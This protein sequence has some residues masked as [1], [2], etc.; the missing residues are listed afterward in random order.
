MIIMDT[1]IVEQLHAI[2]KP[3]LVELCL[4]TP[5]AT[6]SALAECIILMLVNGK[7]QEQLA[8]ELSGDFLNLDPD[9]SGAREFALWLFQQVHYLQSGGQAMSVVASEQ[10]AQALSGEGGMGSPEREAQNMLP[11]TMLR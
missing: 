11:S 8:S 6:D 9:D 3:K 2:I 4:N 10:A 7:T 1:P 5:D